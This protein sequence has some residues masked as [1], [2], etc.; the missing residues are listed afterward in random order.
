VA[1]DVRRIEL[2]VT[3]ALLFRNFQ[4]ASIVVRMERGEGE[5]VRGER[6]SDRERQNEVAKW[7][8]CL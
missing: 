8:I 4:S 3:S 6:E 2:S 5:G 7:F 1:T